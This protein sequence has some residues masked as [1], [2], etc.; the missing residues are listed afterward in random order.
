[1]GTFADTRTAKPTAKVITVDTPQALGDA[2]AIG[3]NNAT[4]AAMTNGANWIMAMKIDDDRPMWGYQ[5]GA[6]S[7]PLVDEID[8]L[9][10]QFV[11]GGVERRHHR[12]VVVPHQ[13]QEPR[14]LSSGLTHVGE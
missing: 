2:I 9:S 5:K 14:T 7:A 1:M 6:R 8:N 10:P 4:A 12:Y 11:V 13:S 3:R